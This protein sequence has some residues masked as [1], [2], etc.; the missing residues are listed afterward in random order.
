MGEFD[1]ENGAKVQYYFANDEKN[2]SVSDAL[3]VRNTKFEDYDI[4]IG[5]AGNNPALTTTAL[6]QSVRDVRRAGVPFV[7]L[8]TYDGTGDIEEL[9]DGEQTE[10][11][12]LGA[13]FIPVHDMVQDLVNMTKGAVE[14]E[15]N[16]HYC[17]PG[18]PNELGLLFLRIIWAHWVETHPSDSV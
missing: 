7:W 17:M 16:I 4:V 3:R 2:K 14:H 8:T 1:F 6:M 10:F 12:E 5:N 9:A 18:P 13:K 15:V 11:F